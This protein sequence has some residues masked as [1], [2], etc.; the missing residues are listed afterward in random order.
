VILFN[1]GASFSPQLRAGTGTTPG[2]VTSAD[3]NGDGLFDLAVANTGAAAN[4]VTILLRAAG[5]GFNAEGAAIPVGGKPGGLVTADFNGDGHPDL[6]V[7][8]YSGNAVVVLLRNAANN[9]FAQEGAAIPVGTG[10]VGIASADFDRDGRPDLAVADNGGAV[11]ILRRNAAGGFT[12]DPATPLAGAPNGVATGDF[13]GDGRPDLAVSTLVTGTNG[14]FSALLNPAP[15]QP[16]PTPTPTPT[17]LPA[18]VAGKS[19][20]LK[21]VSGKVSIKRPGSRSYVALTE[22]VQIPVGTTVDARKGR[23]T[24]TAAQ[25]KGRTASSDFYDGIFKIGQTKGSKPLTTLALTQALSCPKGKSAAAA[26]KKPKTRKL[27]GSG[28]GSF[29]TRGQYSSATVRGTT[30][31]VQDSCT[32]T[33]TRVT[34]GVVSVRDDVKHKTVVVRAGHRYTARAKR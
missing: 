9:G 29:R 31:L 21:P 19:V 13:D 5:G 24:L 23:V 1:T 20:N 32:S 6:A 25:G 30:W 11:D 22:G 8:S 10:P 2:P 12:R 16:T 7:T 26:A 17:P 27:W 14:T 15:A 4:S 18:P 33:L 28:S 3:F 34:K